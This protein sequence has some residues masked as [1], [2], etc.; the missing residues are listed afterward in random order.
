MT[1]IF[2]LN[3]QGQQQVTI[4]GEVKNTQ[5]EPLPGASV[6]VSGTNIGV[7]TDA[8]GA[9]S[10]SCKSNSIL[11]FSFSGFETQ[12]KPVSSTTNWSIRLENSQ[13]VLGEVVVTALGISRQLKSITYASQKVDGDELTKVPETNLMNSLSGKVSGITISRNSSGVGGS[14]KVLLRGSRSIQG[15]NQPLYVIDG[16]P[17]FNFLHESI[18]QS[19]SSMDGG[20]G[21]SNLAPDD[22]ENITVLK[23]AAAAALYGSQAANGV[24]MITTKKGKAGISKIDF[25]SGFTLDRAAFEPELQNSYGETSPGSEESWGAP[26]SN[27]K[28]N[29]K[30]FF[31]TGKTWINAISVSSGT[32]KNQTYLSYS[33]TTANGIVENNKMLK[34]NITIRQTANL[35]NNKL[36]IGGNVNIIN[37][38]VDNPQVSGLNA[39][40]LYGLYSF[41]RGLDF[42]QYKNYERFDS[43][44]H[45]YTQ[46]W[47]FISANNQN[48]YWITNRTL[49]AN[50]RNR[51]IAN[52]TAKFNI[53]SWLNFQ[54][55]G[56][57]DKINDVNSIKY[58]V[59]T[60]EA[61]GGLNG[62]YSI[63][64]MTN[65]MYYGDALLNFAKTYGK[66]NV[67]GLL[68]T[69]ITD[70]RVN[71]ESAASTSLHIPNIFTIQNMD[72][73]SGGYARSLSEQHQQLQAVF[74][75]IGL[76]YDDWLN[77][78]ITGRND[79]SSNLSYTPNGSYFYPF[80]G[81]GLLLHR[82]M[83][84]PKIISY[85]KLRGS[86]AIVG[87][88][89]PVYV[90]NPQ[91]YIDGQGNISFNNKAPFTDLKPEKS[92]SGELGLDMRFLDDQFSLNI[93]YY[94]TNSIN[95]FFPVLV[96]PGT[97]YSTRFIN[98]GNIQNSGIEATI[99]C[100]MRAGKNLNWRST[101]NF[102]TNKNV[103]KEL[104][105]G[106][107]QYVLTNDINGYY[108]I[109]SVGGSYGD[110]YG[111][112]LKHDST[113]RV[114]IGPGGKP[115]IQSGNPSFL[116][117][118]NPKFQ[119]GWNNTFNFKSFSLSFLL[120]GHFGG[121][122]M[123]M[124]QEVL[125]AM[126]V[127]KASGDARTDGG[128]KVNGVLE[129]TDTPVTTVDASDWYHTIG[130]RAGVAGEYMYDATVVRLR[131][132]SFG[133]S[134][135]KTMLKNS[136]VKS[137]RLSLIGRNLIY[138]YRKAP[139]D[140][141]ATFS[142][143][144]GYSGI[145]VFSLP[146]TRSYG[147]NLN[148]SF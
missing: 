119:L 103:V 29:I 141:E 50:K 111:H 82:A 27:A 53:N 116:G 49:Y 47:P 142:S 129:N 72:P 33:N 44:R 7:L 41:P 16:V 43:V 28:N 120:D 79:W 98:G 6:S 91:N 106:I 112:V 135:P 52:I 139:F 143:G 34:H 31:Q 90:T 20:D 102:N 18:N 114:V 107:D 115:V 26:I 54:L 67:N 66:I 97:G 5:G 86:Y 8:Q 24:I 14:V 136:F 57:V 23:G 30:D 84:L 38:V 1:L 92:K 9:F 131:Q 10:I 60:V 124:T 63:L 2:S 22:I 126:G 96:P 81:L 71:G 59:G 113:G 77:L 118:S 122:V 32:D 140:P 75:S 123:S 64:N 130:G 125:D 100:T 85:A 48:P 101:I 70:S 89:V 36:N 62:G 51:A 15:N 134:L 17:M 39:T 117:N 121:K 94:K 104:S 83:R 61:Y 68:G 108:S 73:A 13:S 148:I 127:S 95:Q 128:V 25:S 110:I 69:S 4:S 55:R 145:D 105:P 3:V 132:L 144:N 80:F 146:A 45:I 147:F 19:F 35:F 99:G 40:S 93:T 65:T 137:I 138:F 78:D 88:T 42:S 11:V 58:Y 109:L 12:E 74:G 21:I 46:N 87:N 56:N 133:Y 76:T 37:Q